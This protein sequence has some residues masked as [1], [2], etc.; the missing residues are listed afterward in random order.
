MCSTNA[1]FMLLV[2]TALIQA[3]ATKSE[4][5]HQFSADIKSQVRTYIILA[6]LIFFLTALQIF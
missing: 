2:Q 3:Q 4:C 5:V 1:Y 6:P